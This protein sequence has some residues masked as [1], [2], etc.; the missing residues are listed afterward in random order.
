MELV[1]L[2]VVLFA[3]SLI[4]VVAVTLLSTLKRRTKG[5]SKDYAEQ[6]V[7]RRFTHGRTIGARFA[8]EGRRWIW[9]FDVLEGKE[10]H[11][12]SVD[13]R[14]AVVIRDRSVRQ[15]HPAPTFGKPMLGKR[16]G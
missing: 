14:T 16:I 6:I 8:K 1:G 5:I 12:L 2:I 11:R 4:V 13:A 15:G 9:E 3:A 7:M 10:I